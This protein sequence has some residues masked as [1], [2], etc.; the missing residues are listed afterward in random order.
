M[1][2]FKGVLWIFGCFVAL[3]GVILAFKYF[4]AGVVIFISGVCITPASPLIKLSARLQ[5][6][7]KGGLNKFSLKVLPFLLPLSLF[8][9]GMLLIGVSEESTTNPDHAIESAPAFTKEEKMA[10]KAAAVK[11]KEDERQEKATREAKEELEKVAANAR[12]YAISFGQTAVKESLRDP[13]SVQWKWKAVNLDNGALCYLY[14]AKNGFGGYTDDGTVIHNGNEA[15]RFSW[16]P[17]G[18]S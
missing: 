14:R 1:R 11:A 16:R 12:L 2:F 3:I 8:F 9:V 7:Y 17:V 6:R 4:M 15:P 13:D 10:E 18:L 5:S